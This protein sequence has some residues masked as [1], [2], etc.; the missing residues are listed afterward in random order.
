[1]IND[2]EEQPLEQTP[3]PEEEPQLSAPE[4]PVGVPTADPVHAEETKWTVGQWGG[5]PNYECVDCP[6]STLDL[7]KM[8]EHRN[9]VHSPAPEPAPES[10][11]PRRRYMRRE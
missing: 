5:L 7:E 8:V 4:E 11:E 6:F 2:A 3:V 10:A 1:M 9:T